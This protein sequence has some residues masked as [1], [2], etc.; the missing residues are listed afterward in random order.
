[1]RAITITIINAFYRALSKLSKYFLIISNIQERL[2]LIIKKIPDIS[3]LIKKISGAFKTIYV[4][5]DDF[6][7]SGQ[8]F[9]D[10]L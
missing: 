7:F 6:Q 5:T 3:I 10:D 8:I 2:V 9:P 4:F 1:M